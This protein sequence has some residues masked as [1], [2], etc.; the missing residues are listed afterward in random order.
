MPVGWIGWLLLI[1]GLIVIGYAATVVVGMLAPPRI[2]AIRTIRTQLIA[3]GI[4]PRT[5]S[6]ACISEMADNS[7]NIAKM[8]AMVTPG[9]WRS[10]LQEIAEGTAAMVHA[11][12]IGGGDCS[13]ER[14]RKEA[15]M[16]TA[17]W[18]WQVLAKHDP[19]RFALENLEA[20]Q[21]TNYIMRS[22]SE[23]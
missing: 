12:I 4:E 2:L 3:L 6:D 7:I 10:H 23:R 15:E 1:V 11:V 9:P 8:E 14:I 16:G 22:G 18:V 17:P 21:D 5:F 19:K 20:M 13:A